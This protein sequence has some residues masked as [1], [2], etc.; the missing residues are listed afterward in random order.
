MKNTKTKIIAIITIIL[1]L[2]LIA[3]SFYF[4]KRPKINFIDIS[5]KIQKNTLQNINMEYLYSENVGINIKELSISDNTL[6][7]IFSFKLENQ[8]ISSKPLHTN[9]LIYDDSNNIYGELSQVP[10]NNKNLGITKNLNSATTYSLISNSEN[11]ATYQLLL[12]SPTQ[13]FPHDKELYI[14][15]NNLEFTDDNGNV[16]N[17]TPE[18]NFSINS[19]D[20][21]VPSIQYKLK[22]NVD[23]FDLHS[24]YVSNYL[25]TIVYEATNNNFNVNIVDNNGT[26]FKS[27]TSSNKSFRE[28]S[29]EFNTSNITQ[30]LYLRISD[31]SF[32]KDIELEEIK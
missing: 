11:D 32:S 16:T 15:I 1:I 18:W 10:S 14:H 3:I 28:L 5:S 24:M 19:A 30:P 31:G 20:I 23:G 29:Y 27:F 6:N 17:F 21:Y 12:Y 26:L 25:T 13:P 2:I 8:K 4:F 22:E 7:F 9:I